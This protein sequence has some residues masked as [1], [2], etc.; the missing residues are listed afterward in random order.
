MA[1]KR[2]TN[3]NKYNSILQQYYIYITIIL[4]LL[5]NKYKTLI[6]SIGGNLYEYNR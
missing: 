5:T 6:C 3:L 4:G 2:L 1:C